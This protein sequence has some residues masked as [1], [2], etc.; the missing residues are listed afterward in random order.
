MAR[1]VETLT[2]LLAAAAELEKVDRKLVP[3]YATGAYEALVNQRISV[4]R[5]VRFEGRQTLQSS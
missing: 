4:L 3:V 2:N 1:P 5:E